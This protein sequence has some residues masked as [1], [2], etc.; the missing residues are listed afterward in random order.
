LSFFCFFFFVQLPKN[1]NCPIDENSP[2]LVT[3]PLSCSS[4]RSPR[5][6]M[7]SPSRWARPS[8]SW[9]AYGHENLQINALVA[10]LYRATKG[11]RI[12]ENIRYDV[13]YFQ[14]FITSYVWRHKIFSIFYDVIVMTS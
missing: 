4:Q 9:P 1:Q 6:L 14:Y 11:R 8:P 10:W 13:V 3:L 2:N 5:L 12:Y 7:Y